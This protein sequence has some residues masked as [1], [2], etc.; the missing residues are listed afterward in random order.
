MF[1]TVL[2]FPG[3]GSHEIGMGSDLFK[4]DAWTRNLVRHASERLGEDLERLCLRGPEKRLIQSRFV[5]P[6]LVA[7]SLGYWRHLANAGVI[8]T[9]VAG[10]SLGEITALAA[11]GVISPE[12]AMAVER[13]QCMDEA[14]QINPGGMAAVFLTLHDVAQKIERFA[15]VNQVFIA[16][17]NAP[18]QVVVSASSEQL[19]LFC[20]NMNAESPGLC[21][22]LFVSGP[23][24]SPLL[25]D[26]QQ[27]FADWLVNQ[28]FIKPDIVVIPNTTAT[29]ETEPERLRHASIEQLTG[30][31]RWRETMQA[32]KAS[33]P[34]FMLEIGPR[35]VLSGLAR[36]NGIGNEVAVYSLSTLEGVKRV[37]A[38]IMTKQE[39]QQ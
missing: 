30:Q 3:Q 26:A 22:Q 12:Q 19:A 7:V 8:P 15:M 14:G 35:R 39:K 31:V 29:P 9:A 5:Q 21:K 32:L 25:N 33:N 34:D 11:A 13:G 2:L 28:P 24:H 16:N 36:L 4:A 27:K 23:W 17:D 37:L 10:H 1:R 6:L 20:K 38:E 18:D